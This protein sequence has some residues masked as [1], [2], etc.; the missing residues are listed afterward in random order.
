MFSRYFCYPS[1]IHYSFLV[2]SL[3]NLVDCL[4]T[5][6]Q[7]FKGKLKAP[8][9]KNPLDAQKSLRSFSPT[10]PNNEVRFIENNQSPSNPSQLEQ[11][12]EVRAKEPMIY[13]NPKRKCSVN[14]KTKQADYNY[15]SKLARIFC[16]G[17]TKFFPHSVIEVHNKKENLVSEH[18]QTER[19]GF[20]RFN[21]SIQSAVVSYSPSFSISTN[22]GNSQAKP[23]TLSKCK[24]RKHVSKMNVSS[25]L[26]LHS[27]S[28]SAPASNLL[29]AN[30]ESGP[31]QS[32]VSSARS[33][34]LMK[35]DISL[36]QSNSSLFTEHRKG[37]GVQTQVGKSVKHEVYLMKSE[38]KKGKVGK[39]KIAPSL[40]DNILPT[41]NNKKQH[42]HLFGVVGL[43]FKR[44]SRKSAGNI[45]QADK[46]SSETK[47]NRR[48]V[49]GKLGD[50]YAYLNLSKENDDEK[51]E[52]KV[53]SSEFNRNDV[54]YSHDINKSSDFT[55]ANKNAAATIPQKNEK[56]NNKPFSSNSRINRNATTITQLMAQISKDWMK[57]SYRENGNLTVIVDTPSE[58]QKGYLDR[59]TRFP[60][61]HLSEDQ[62]S[63]FHYETYATDRSSSGRSTTSSEKAITSIT[64][65][66]DSN[67]KIMKS[68]SFASS[69]DKLTEMKTEKEVSL[70][71]QVSGV[72]ASSWSSINGVLSRSNVEQTGSV[73]EKWS[74]QNNNTSQLQKI[75]A[76]KSTG[77]SSKTRNCSVSS[78]SS[79]TQKQ[80][81]TGRKVKGTSEI[82]LL[83]V[84]STELNAS[85]VGNVNDHSLTASC[86]CQT[87]QEFNFPFLRNSHRDLLQLN[88]FRDTRST[89]RNSSVANK[90]IIG[91]S[92]ITTATGTK[93]GTSIPRKSQLTKLDTF[94][95][96]DSFELNQ[97]VVGTKAKSIL[98]KSPGN[99]AKSTATPP[100]T[101]LKER[102]TLTNEKLKRVIFNQHNR[103]THERGNNRITKSAYD[104]DGT[105]GATVHERSSPFLRWNEHERLS[106]DIMK[107]INLSKNFVHQQHKVKQ[108]PKYE[109][110]LI[111]TL[112]SP[113]T[114]YN[115]KQNY[116]KQ[117]FF[118]SIRRKI[119]PTFASNHEQQNQ[120]DMDDKKFTTNWFLKTAISLNKNTNKKLISKTSTDKNNDVPYRLQVKTKSRKNS[121]MSMQ[122]MQHIMH[123]KMSKLMA[124]DS[125]KREINKTLHPS[126]FQQQLLRRKAFTPLESEDSKLS[127]VSS[128]P[129]S[130]F[131]T[132]SS[133]PTKL[134]PLK[135]DIP[136]SSRT[137]TRSSNRKWKLAEEKKTAQGEEIL[138]KNHEFSSRRRP[139]NRTQRK[140]TSRA[141]NM[142]EDAKASIE[143]D[144]SSGT[145]T[146]TQH[147]DD[148]IQTQKRYDG[149]VEG[150]DDVYDRE[151]SMNSNVGENSIDPFPG[152]RPETKAF[153]QL[154]LSS[155]LHPQSDRVSI[156]GKSKAA[157]GGVKRM[158]Y[159]NAEHFTEQENDM[160]KRIKR[161]TRCIT[162]SSTHPVNKGMRIDE[163]CGR[164]SEED[165]GTLDTRNQSRKLIPMK[166]NP[167]ASTHAKKLDEW[168]QTVSPPSMNTNNGTNSEME[169]KKLNVG[170]HY[171]VSGTAEKPPPTTDVSKTSFSSL[172]ETR[173]ENGGMT[174]KMDYNESEKVLT[175]DYNFMLRNRKEKC[176]WYNNH[177]STDDK[178]IKLCTTKQKVNSSV[179]T[180]QPVKNTPTTEIKHSVSD[181]LSSHYTTSSQG[182]A[183]AVGTI[184]GNKHHLQV[185]VSSFSYENMLLETKAMKNDAYLVA[186]DL[187]R[188]NGNDAV[189]ATSL[190]S[191]SMASTTTTEMVVSVTNRAQTKTVT[192]LQ[193]EEVVDALGSTTPSATASSKN[194]DFDSSLLP[195]LTTTTATST[196]FLLNSSPAIFPTV[197]ATLETKAH[198]EA[199]E[200]FSSTANALSNTNSEYQEVKATN[201]FTQEE[202]SFP[203]T[204]LSSPSYS[205][206]LIE[207]PNTNI[208]KGELAT[209]HFISTTTTLQQPTQVSLSDTNTVSRTTTNALS[210]IDLTTRAYE[211]N[212]QEVTHTASVY[213]ENVSPF[214]LITFEITTTTVP[215]NQIT[216]ATGGSHVTPTSMSPS[217][218]LQ[219]TTIS[220][221]KTAEDPTTLSANVDL[222]PTEIPSTEQHVRTTEPTLATTLMSTSDVNLENAI[223]SSRM[224]TTVLPTTS[225]ATL[226]SAV[227]GSG[228]E[229]ISNSSVDATTTYATTVYTTLQ[230]TVGENI[231]ENDSSVG[232]APPMECDHS[233]GL[234]Y[235]EETKNCMC[236]TGMF[237]DDNKK[238]CINLV[239]NECLGEGETSNSDCPLNSVCKPQEVLGS[240]KSLCV[241]DPGYI[242]AH[243]KSQCM[244][245][246]NTT[247]SPL[248]DINI[249]NQCH[250]DFDCV[251]EKM[252][253]AGGKCICKANMTLGMSYA[254]ERSTNG[255]WRNEQQ[256]K[257]FLDYGSDCDP[258]SLNDKCN[259]FR[260]LK[261]SR[262]NAKC[263][264]ADPSNQLYDERTHECVSRAGNFC[265]LTVDSR[266]I[267][268]YKE[269]NEL[270]CIGNSS[271]VR[272]G[273]ETESRFSGTCKCL[274]GYDQHWQGYCTMKGAGSNGSKSNGGI[275]GLLC[276]VGFFNWSKRNLS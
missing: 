77:S 232:D 153:T 132:S 36:S 180:T 122:K 175:S 271:C 115:F 218:P 174:Q 129:E 150:D 273:N 189:T 127:P 96:S 216:S 117:K 19:R 93:S 8:Q 247:C 226:S 52:E 223:I 67:A 188:F 194:Y 108:S 21:P 102:M 104:Y 87:K 257:C 138:G 235:F 253:E 116:T 148:G 197:A 187:L 215:P 68:V 159:D 222:S 1:L 219:F 62:Q 75:K 209:T 55:L 31:V 100:I 24:G 15:E 252:E 261:C 74:L 157:T 160:F 213:T 168:T 85:Q 29:Q 128:L 34:W 207:Q 258:L 30:S 166:G 10:Y 71:V 135:R 144:A 114:S 95:R 103:H 208:D 89:R 139:V 130:R 14:Y 61:S 146:T 272:V 25:T 211:G 227:E 113:I 192:T 179:Q 161:D 111:T 259:D 40:L 170:L 16:N 97:I 107:E 270:R 234:V 134:F 242:S 162:T 177:L 42:Q 53:E 224:T 94:T 59:Y 172:R 105:S 264:C 202:E 165:R 41:L 83:Q 56:N 49:Y 91:N 124:G 60:S 182:H 72:E 43:Y 251:S 78:S 39:V 58:R 48:L 118:E 27:Q 119:F 6:K 86:K 152:A 81:G 11:Y 250:S 240:Q 51:E 217:Q 9:E 205:T 155:L 178:R 7:Q 88:S 13:K 156:L 121:Y 158:P 64:K 245:G 46:H 249:N 63:R 266:A 149:N 82:A 35:F 246:W 125:F 255:T 23:C 220:T 181:K 185:N 126:S 268:E 106:R 171:K 145:P 120:N 274:D 206:L 136:E 198:T 110:I 184:L 173:S 221:T 90:F 143:R 65:N 201:G 267:S 256:I 92:I 191:L 141:Y 263:E 99:S 212:M 22:N 3:L 254:S 73:L 133:A 262:Q 163:G 33:S 231:K 176:G 167:V 265:N 38:M 109:L 147:D 50:E 248:S 214:T 26:R 237:Y 18:Y 44:N 275:L 233:K 54:A 5:S 47:D 241:C 2:F 151:K 131:F 66:L 238:R 32:T 169:S 76:A 193:T 186:K 196:P 225:T 203:S 142:A 195:F 84:I 243:D 229:E 140:G 98:S 230:T 200:S 154:L 199:S 183:N 80:A 101:S 164:H 204:P 17:E 70:P 45:M 239:G 112:H 190:S 12:F 269:M 4:S 20:L 244:A 69:S 137:M 210:E 57:W 79:S 28:N 276:L 260:F 123:K 228:S 37:N 236:A